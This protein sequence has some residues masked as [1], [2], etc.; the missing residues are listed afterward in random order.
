M[1][2]KLITVLGNVGEPSSPTY[3]MVSSAAIPGPQVTGIDFETS[4][5]HARRV[6]GQRKRDKSRRRKVAAQA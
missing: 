5:E 6:R 3:L 1:G 2:K 4:L